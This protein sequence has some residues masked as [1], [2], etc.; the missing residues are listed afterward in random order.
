MNQSSADSDISQVWSWIIQEYTYQIA[1]STEFRFI[2]L[3]VLPKSTNFLCIKLFVGKPAPCSRKFCLDLGDTR[4]CVVVWREDVIMC[5]THTSREK[6]VRGK[7]IVGYGWFILDFTYHSTRK[8]S[9]EGILHERVYLY[10]YYVCRCSV[11][12]LIIFWQVVFLL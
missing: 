1:T 4:T 9:M 12:L 11:C 3:W 10:C 8:S 7:K 6:S 5:V 2:E